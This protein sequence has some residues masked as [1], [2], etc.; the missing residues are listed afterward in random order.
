[1]AK[2]RHVVEAAADRI[3]T[4]GDVLDFAYFFL[5]DSWL[6]YDEKAF[7]KSLGKPGTTELLAKFRD[8]L[9]TAD[10]FDA[11]HLEP[12][13]HQ[14]VQDEGIKVGDIIHSVRIAITGQPVGLGL[15]DSLAILG[16]ETSLRR[17]EHAIHLAMPKG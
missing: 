1:M 8:R 9:A 3:K 15:F 4:A 6:S 2:I 12:L 17:I 5:E 10:P 16:K 13:L 11:A 14:F 7:Q